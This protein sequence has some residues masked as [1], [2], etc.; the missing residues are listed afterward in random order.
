MKISKTVLRP[1][2]G[3]TILLLLITGLFWLSKH[4]VMRCYLV[5]WSD[6]DQIAENVY[7]DPAMPEDNRAHLVAAVTEAKQHIAALFGD[8]QGDAVIIAGHTMSIMNAY[9]GNNYNQVG[10]SYLTALGSY[11][12]LGPGGAQ[13]KDVVAHE[14]A[15]AE[16]A[17]RL[18]Y[19][20]ANQLPDWFEE[21]LALQVDDRYTEAEWLARTSNGAT[22]PDLDEIGIIRHDDWLGYATAKHEVSRWMEAAGPEGLLKFL[23]AVRQGED[24]FLSYQAAEQ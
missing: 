11:I 7:V 1:I 4:P 10:R 12:V 6:L 20:R 9:G 5:S 13:D 2:S 22:A 8:L 21:G 14:L 18:G 23:Q 19:R 24:F 17:Q 15:H 16:V 3:I